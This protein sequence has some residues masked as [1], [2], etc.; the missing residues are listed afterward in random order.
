MLETQSLPRTLNEMLI[1]GAVQRTAKHG[2]QIALE[3]DEETGGYF[4]FNHGTLY[5]ILHHLE[6]EG[7][8]DGTWDT[9]SGR[10]RKKEYALTPAGRAY[11]AARFDE[12]GEL[13]ARLSAFVA[14]RAAIRPGAAAN[15]R[16][17]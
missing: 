9:G 13:H 12:W 10:R 7:L 14:E 17:A 6:K 1:L 11:L 15:Q 8:I 2:Y 4:S 5:P 3:I 16:G